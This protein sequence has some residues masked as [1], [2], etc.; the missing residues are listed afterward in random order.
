MKKRE[1]ILKE[2]L[3][4][5]IYIDKLRKEAETNKM[6][7]DIN[8]KYDYIK[9]DLPVPFY[10]DENKLEKLKNSN[11]NKCLIC[12][13]EFKIKEQVLYLPC[14]H[15]FHSRCIVR[16]LLDKTTCPI[17]AT[18]YKMN[19][20]VKKE[21]KEELTFD[22]LFNE[23]IPSKE[24]NFLNNN[25]NNYYNNNNNIFNYFI[26]NNNNFVNNINNMYRPNNM[27]NNYNN[28]YVSN[29]IN[30]NCNNMYSPYNNM[31]I[32][33]KYLFGVNNDMNSINN[34]GTFNNNN[35]KRENFNFRGRGRGN[36]RGGDKGN[37]RGRG[38][39]NYRREARGNYKVV[40]KG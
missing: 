30:P 8:D 35:N 33:Y 24:D 25:N 29:N 32:N 5:E 9:N 26:F 21:E 11:N 23:D 6:I 38:R 36:F 12:L 13:E 22:Q 18:N 40:G 10:L 3:E 27:M 19:D 4:K 1:K 14:L 34:I 17:C 15:L 20:V 39:G 31:Y 16:W 37:Y 2:I 7:R 28:I